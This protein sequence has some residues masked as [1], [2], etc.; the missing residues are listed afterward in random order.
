MFVLISGGVSCDILVITNKGK[1]HK[2]R[3]DTTNKKYIT[4]FKEMNKQ[5]VERENVA[6]QCSHMTIQ[7][8]LTL[9]AV[10]LK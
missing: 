9:T 5:Q 7:V 10:P 6:H 3:K 8:V 2:V 1:H 4:T